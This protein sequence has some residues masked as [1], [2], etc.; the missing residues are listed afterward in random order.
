MIFK[1]ELIKKIIFFFYWDILAKS[2]RHDKNH[3]TTKKILGKKKKMRYIAVLVCRSYEEVI[4]RN[5]TGLM[6][7]PNRFVK[8]NFL[9]GHLVYQNPVIKKFLLPRFWGVE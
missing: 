1:S 9:F 5:W 8:R 7:N 2:I 3:S 6:Q 4:Y